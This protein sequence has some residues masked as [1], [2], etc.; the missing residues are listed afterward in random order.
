MEIKENSLE[1]IKGLS[2]KIEVSLVAEDF[3]SA[4]HLLLLL[5]AKADEADTVIATFE[6]NGQ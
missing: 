4:S 1:E 2:S 3:A 5:I 6:V